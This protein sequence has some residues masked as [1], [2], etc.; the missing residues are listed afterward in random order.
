[1]GTGTVKAARDFLM[2]L[3]LRQFAGDSEDAFQYVLDRRTIECRDKLPRKSWGAARK[4]LNIFLRGALYNRFLCEH[5][6]L[7]VTEP[8]LEV[9]LDSF[10]AIGL[11]KEEGGTSL[12]PWKTIIRLEPEVSAKYQAFARQVAQRKGCSR[13]HLDLWYW[14]ADGSE[15]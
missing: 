7:G 4:F 2:H 11:R 3:D 12:P 5:Y 1:M 8:F 13:V 10:V 14:R 15:G 6:H 9:P